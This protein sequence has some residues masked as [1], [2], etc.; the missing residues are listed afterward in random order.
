M[1]TD[2][3]GEIYEVGSNVRHLKKG[4]RVLGHVHSLLTGDPKDGGF[5][6]YSRVAATN[7]V[8]IPDSLSF[9]EAAVLPL[10]INTAADGLYKS[11]EKGFLGL[12]YPTLVSTTWHCHP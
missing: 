8:K 3:A 11:R 7:T 6:L 5:Q 10:A 12:E 2:S 1:G 9:K 4:D